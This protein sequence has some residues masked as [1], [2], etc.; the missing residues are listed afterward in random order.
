MIEAVPGRLERG[1]VGLLLVHLA[2]GGQEQDLV[3]LLHEIARSEKPLATVVLSESDCPDLK[4][5]LLR[6]GV[7][8]CL[9]RPFNVSRLAFLVD[10]LTVWPRYQRSQIAGS[11]Q[12]RAGEWQSAAG[13]FL[14]AGPAMQGLMEQVKAV[15]PLETTILLTGETGTGKTCLAR[16]IQQL[17]PRKTGPFLTVECGAISPALFES[18]LFGY[19]RGAFTGADRDH[20]GKLAEVQDGTLLLDDVD[21]VP[22][23]AQPK[24]LRAVEERLFE[25][26]GSNRL[27]SFHARLIVTANRSLEEEVAV[28]RFRPDLYYRLNVAELHLPALRDCREL[29]RPLTDRFLADYCSRSGRQIR[30]VSPAALEAFEAYDWPGNVRQLRNVIERAVALRAEGTIDIGDLPQSIRSYS[31]SADLAAN[32]VHLG[33]ANRL[34]QARQHAELNQLMQALKHNGNNRTGAAAELGISRVTL[35]KKLHL[36]GLI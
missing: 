2:D 16:I 35:Y 36:Y 7:V 33:T 3:R 31:P 23:Q 20:V 30:G 13:D 21:C 1:D 34:A 26:L 28:G 17:S 8:D 32:P 5:R 19:V 12:S 15:A 25:P 10:T 4:L 11:T 14:W 27:H 6:C 29:I 22:L 18:E 24:L 9:S